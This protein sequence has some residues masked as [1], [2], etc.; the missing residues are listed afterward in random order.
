[1]QADARCDVV[2][3]GCGTSGL[4]TALSLPRSLSVVMLS[5]GPLR[6]CNSMLAQGGICVLRDEGDYEAFFE[7]TMR[8]G[9]GENRPDSVDVMIR[10]SRSIIEALLALGVRFAKTP[11]GDL[12]YALEAGHSRPRI[13]YCEDA[14]G[15][16]ITTKLLDEAAGRP[17]IRIIEHASMV[18]ILE[19][20]RR[21]EGL[22]ME[23]S[24]GRVSAVR[25][26]FTVLATGGIGGLYTR[27]TNYPIM[28]G[29]GCRIAAAHGIALES[30]DCVQIHPTSLYT[31]KAG[32]AFLISEAARGYGAVLLDGKG[33]RF[34][35]ELKPRD[36]V[37]ASIE[38]QMKKEGSLH[39]WLSFE[40]LDPD[41][42]KA[43]FPG[44]YKHCLEEGY[45][46][47]RE[48]IPVVPA[49]HYFMGGVR[50]D[51][52]S[53]TSMEDLYAVGETSCNGVHGKNRLASNS[54][55]ESL[56][57]AKRAAEDVALRLGFEGVSDSE[58]GFA[59]EE[60]F[61]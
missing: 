22:L 43:R 49:Q 29:D 45:D 50:V 48:P 28:T 23:D 61:V 6:E 59:R 3:A 20:G 21:C 1:M 18:D 31:E 30:M 12:D 13:C 42:V 46:I 60:A 41:C 17:N 54:L 15:R 53:K 52:H 51:T 38:R 37:T 36:V 58:V 44:I 26:R 10:E 33:R 55:L 35:D 4:Y 34:T 11:A 7:D 32:R 14:T 16:E 39:V 9:H 2:I 19:N 25:A 40:G 27:S 24:S 8:A 57:F 5:K 47:T 56:V